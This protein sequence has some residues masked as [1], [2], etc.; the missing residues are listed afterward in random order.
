VLPLGRRFGEFDERQW[1]ML[2]DI[3]F[4]ERLI[5]DTFNLSAAVNYDVLRA[6]HRRPLSFAGER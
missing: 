3:M 6:A 5:D 2:R 1:K 4:N